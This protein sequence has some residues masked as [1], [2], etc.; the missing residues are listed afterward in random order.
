MD[1]LQEFRY[2]FFG[3]PPKG[4][5]EWG[6]T[7]IFFGLLFALPGAISIVTYWRDRRLGEPDGKPPGL[8]VFI[9]VLLPVLP[10]CIGLWLSRPAG[11]GAFFFLGEGLILLTGI[12]FCTYGVF[13]FRGEHALR[14]PCWGGSFLGIGCFCLTGGGLSLSHNVRVWTYNRSANV[15]E[16][17]KEYDKAIADYSEAIRLEP[18]HGAAFIGRGIAY[19]GNKKYDKAI[20]D[21]SEAIRLDPSSAYAYSNLAWVLA[22]CPEAVLRN[23]EKAIENATQACELSHW[24]NANHLDT[25]AAAKAESKNFDEAVKWQK[26]AMDLRFPDWF[27]LNGV[28]GQR[29]GVVNIPDLPDSIVSQ[30][31]GGLPAFKQDCQRLRL[32]QEGKPYRDVSK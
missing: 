27:I 30:R 7:L 15:Y 12:V 10:A 24:K 17:N 29:D 13:C 6:F 21:F 28:K 22:T 18:T 20:S 16:D 9:L 8:G 32:Y 3:P 14:R 4:V 26:K 1:M 19:T 25:L 31:F 5:V 2:P 11:P 23:G